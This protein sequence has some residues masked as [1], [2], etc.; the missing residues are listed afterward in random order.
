MC[1][2]ESDARTTPSIA[3]REFVSQLPEIVIT[4]EKVLKTLSAVN[5]NKSQGPDANSLLTMSFPK[6]WKQ[7]SVCAIHTKGSKSKPEN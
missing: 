3:V 2:N 4:K 5:I 7:A 6:V 1:T